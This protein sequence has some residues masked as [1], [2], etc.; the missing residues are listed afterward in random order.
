MKYDKL[1]LPPGVSPQERTRQFMNR[2]AL[3]RQEIEK[4]SAALR[5][6]ANGAVMD[7]ETFFREMVAR[8]VEAERRL[9]ALRKIMVAIDDQRAL[10]RSFNNSAALTGLVDKIR[11]L[12]SEGL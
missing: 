2:S 9:E 8:G 7:A 10:P 3:A 11:T 12:A 4:S 1:A 6:A 5:E